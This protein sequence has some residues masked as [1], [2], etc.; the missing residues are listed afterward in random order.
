MLGDEEDDRVA[1]ADELEQDVLPLLAI[2]QVAAIDVDRE[3]VGLQRFDQAIGGGHVVAR[4]GNED[5]EF[6]GGVGNGWIWHR[7]GEGNGVRDREIPFARDAINCAHGIN[8][9]S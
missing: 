6:L 5:A 2:G 7:S 4:I 9:Q 1:V 8:P 3:A